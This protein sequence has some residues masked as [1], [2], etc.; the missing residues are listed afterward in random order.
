MPPRKAG[1]RCSSYFKVMNRELTDPENIWPLRGVLA[2][3][4]IWKSFSSSH[5]CCRILGPS[6]GVR[7]YPMAEPWPPGLFCHVSICGWKATDGARRDLS[8]ADAAGGLRSCPTTLVFYLNNCLK[9]LVVADCPGALSA[10][11]LPKSVL[12]EISHVDPY[13]SGSNRM[14]HTRI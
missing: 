13:P 14:N 3:C 9:H 2:I 5:W 12:Q 6:F 10:N 11:F 7:L 8:L 4:M 1:M